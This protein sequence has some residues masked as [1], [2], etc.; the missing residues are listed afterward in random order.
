MMKTEDF[1]V[2]VNGEQY[3]IKTTLPEGPENVDHEVWQHDKLLFVLNP[4]LNNCDEP[5]WSLKNEYADKNIS[6]EL[7]QEI[8]EKIEMH[9]V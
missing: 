4:H 3:Q 9:Y 8:G 6:K 1:F 2:E 5:C 7:V